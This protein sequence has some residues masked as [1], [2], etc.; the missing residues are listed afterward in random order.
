MKEK[1]MKKMLKHRAALILYLLGLT[2]LVVIAQT[3]T[4]FPCSALELKVSALELRIKAEAARADLNATR[5]EVA[6]KE[7]SK[8]RSTY[9]GMA[10]QLS[11]EQSRSSTL[12]DINQNSQQQITDL[13][14][15]LA[16]ANTTISTVTFERDKALTKIKNANG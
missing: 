7:L 1:L 15:K 2:C 10:Q 13:K 4:Q 3:P 5:R 11:A 16:A 12:S 14:N 6:E 9:G 8:Q